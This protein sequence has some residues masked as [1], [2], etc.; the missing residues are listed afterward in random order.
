VTN[1]ERLRAVGIGAGVVVTAF[2]AIN[3]E[4]LAAVVFG[5][6]TVAVAVAAMHERRS[7]R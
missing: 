1:R 6:A 7:R 3:G 4:R 5:L 2:A